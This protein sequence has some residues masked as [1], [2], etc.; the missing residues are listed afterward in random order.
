V[1]AAGPFS[2]E[3]PQA[4]DSGSRGAPSTEPPS[5]GPSGTGPSG[6]APSNAGPSSTGAGAGEPDTSSAAFANPAPLGG[7][8]GPPASFLAELAAA[9]SRRAPQ[10]TAR[11]NFSDAFTRLE[12][13]F[14]A[15]TPGSV[16]PGAV[17]PGSVTPRAA[18]AGS[19][20]PGSPAAP[21][22]VP[23]TRTQAVEQS[24]SMLHRLGDRYVAERLRP[25]IEELAA[26]ATERALEEGLGRI[27][28][29]LAGGFDATVE[30]FRFLGARV[31]AIEDL[32]TREREPIDAVAWLAPP[33][34]LG[35]WSGPVADWIADSHPAG[36]V[37]HGECGEGEL[38]VAI[39]EAGL[40][41]RGAEPRGAV[42][43]RAAERGVDVYIGHVSELISSM[44]TGSLGGLVL[45]GVVDRAPL[46]ELV[47]LLDLATGRLAPGAPLV[48]V[49]TLPEAAARGWDAVARDLLPGRP[50]HPET[51][52][53]LL[54]RAG[55]VEVG[56][57]VPDPAGR[58]GDRESGR[59]GAGRETYAVKGRRPS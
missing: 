32:A 18:T 17:T 52:D 55:Y 15:V 4:P 16:A 9:F 36:E 47:G 53:L 14:G 43:W 30:A 33:P 20:T 59:A 3:H 50:L 19:V 24:H 39:A 8:K 5:T 38:T 57:L 34:A 48:V 56:R 44:A 49:S 25:W 28:G 40:T 26:A 7:A 10:G 45:S 42:A 46:G 23:G 22:P 35:E 12:K 21:A 13:R 29:D 51:W 11:W 2:D 1:T 41:V 31:E 6:T 54:L 27:E 37:V 58:G